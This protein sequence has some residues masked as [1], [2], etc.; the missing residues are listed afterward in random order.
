MGLSVWLSLSLAAGFFGASAARAQAEDPRPDIL[1]IYLDDVS[2]HDGRLWSEPER[3]PTLADLFVETASTFSSAFG[4]TPLC[5]P[6]R[7]ATLTGL[8]TTSHG[9]DANDVTLFDP[10]V[11]LATE[12]Q[13]SGYRTVYVGKFMNGLRSGVP[14]AKVR[15]YARGWDVFDIQYE[16]NGRFLDYALWTRDGIIRFGDRPRDHSTR[17]FGQRTAAHLRKA[18]PGTPVFAFVSPVDLHAPNRPME[19][20]VGAPVCRAIEPWAPPNYNERD[21]SDKP[22]YVR[23]RPRYGRPAWPMRRYCEEMLGVDRMVARIARVQEQRGR[24]DDT[25]FIFTADNGSGWGAHRL[26]QVKGVPYATPIPLA[27]RWPARW[28]STAR[29]IAEPVSN[30]DLAPTLCELAGCTL[31]PFPDGPVEADGL[32]LLPLLDG[33]ATSLGRDAIREQSGPSLWT[34]EFWA[35][36]TTPAH[37]LGLWH[38]IEY[39]T[40]ERELYDSVEDPWELENLAADPAR[41]AVVAELAVRLRAEFPDLPGPPE[42]PGANDAP[43]TSG[44]PDPSPGA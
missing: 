37:P 40:G 10:R 39:E 34:P 41:A 7:A 29:S 3:T 1:V 30:I 9:V 33:L 42:T 20:F 43:D 27:V 44:T 38:Y 16:D 6:G 17:V 11:T 32:S 4:E 19:A 2:P 5:C 12:L 25:L 15:R 14:R 31:G 8:H 23:E 18:A 22:A 21:V 13:D 36:R 28:G 26:G 24:L 35:L